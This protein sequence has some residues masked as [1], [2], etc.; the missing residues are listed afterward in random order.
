M[1]FGCVEGHNFLMKRE[2]RWFEID[3]LHICETNVKQIEN[4][5][6]LNVKLCGYMNLIIKPLGVTLRS[7]IYWLKPCFIGSSCTKYDIKC[8]KVFNIAM[9]TL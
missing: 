3:C 7:T 9:L 6:I 4:I 2:V 5:M 8:H 1:K